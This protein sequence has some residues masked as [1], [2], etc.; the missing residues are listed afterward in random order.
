MFHPWSIEHSTRR[1]RILAHHVPARTSSTWR[2]SRQSIRE[3]DRGM[4]ESSLYHLYGF[5][6]ESELDLPEVLAAPTPA[7]DRRRDRCL[8]PA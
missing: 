1:A 8:P 4:T 5:T 7:V 2:I 3:G 6:L